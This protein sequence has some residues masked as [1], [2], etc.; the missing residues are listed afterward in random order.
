MEKKKIGEILSFRLICL[1]FWENL[2]EFF[3]AWVFFGLSFFCLEFFAKCPKKPESILTIHTPVNKCVYIRWLVESEWWV[4]RHQWFSKG[5]PTQATFHLY[6]P[7][8][9]HI[10][11]WKCRVEAMAAVVHQSFSQMLYGLQMALPG[12]RCNPSYFFMSNFWTPFLISCTH[13]ASNFTFTTYPPVK[14]L[15]K[16]RFMFHEKPV[17]LETIRFNWL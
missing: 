15:A 12:M 3:S 9:P 10:R 13:S 17:K 7:E 14:L 6:S 1:S 4:W 5:G 2:L 11:C 8:I 16:I